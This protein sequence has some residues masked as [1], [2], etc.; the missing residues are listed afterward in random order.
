MGRLIQLE[1]NDGKIWVESTDVYFEEGLAPAPELRK[2]KR[3]S[4]N[5]RGNKIIL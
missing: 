2:Q 4:K 1:Y 5:V 3:I